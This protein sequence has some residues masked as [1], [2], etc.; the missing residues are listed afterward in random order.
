MSA[1][2]GVFV[3]YTYLGV[4]ALFY[5]HT[6]KRGRN[7]ITLEKICEDRGLTPQI[8]MGSR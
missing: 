8:I 2:L 7:R 5:G 6:S 1:C 4:G 3:G